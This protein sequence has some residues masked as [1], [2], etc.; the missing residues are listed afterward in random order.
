MSRQEIENEVSSLISDVLQLSTEKPP[1]DVHREE[2]DEWDSLG[3]LRIFMAI[4]NIYA[5]KIPIDP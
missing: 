4:E 5:I 3:H 2:I 1:V